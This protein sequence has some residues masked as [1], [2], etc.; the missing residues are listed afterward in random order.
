[1][2]ESRVSSHRP[3]YEVAAF[4]VSAVLI[5]LAIGVPGVSNESRVSVIAAIVGAWL[6]LARQHRRED[7]ER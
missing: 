2:A 1:M 4:V 7:D 6:L 3:P 5:G